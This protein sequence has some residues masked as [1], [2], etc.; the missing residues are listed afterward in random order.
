[1]F[2]CTLPVPDEED[3]VWEILSFHFFN[4]KTHFNAACSFSLACLIAAIA[5]LLSL[6]TAFVFSGRRDVVEADPP[7]RSRDLDLDL[8]RV[9]RE[10]KKGA[11]GKTR[12]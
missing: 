1:M 3:V 8:D 7:L 10:L 9:L 4:K 11:E 5:L 2:G 6:S 12:W